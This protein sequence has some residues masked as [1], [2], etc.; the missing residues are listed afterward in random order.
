MNGILGLLVREHF[1]GVAGNA[2]EPAYTW[3]H[4]KHAEDFADTNGRLFANK[5]ER[6]KPELWVILF[7]LV[8]TDTYASVVD[9]DFGL[10]QFG[11]YIVTRKLVFLFL[12]W[13]VFSD[14]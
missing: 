14:I 2:A 12:I 10:I 13:L 8:L 4:Y 3:N 9:I 6:V 11:L 7:F 1:P 5:A